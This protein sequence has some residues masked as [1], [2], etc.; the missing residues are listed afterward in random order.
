MELGHIPQILLTPALTAALARA[1]DIAV[2]SGAREVAVEH[3]LFALCDDPD[4][5]SVLETSRV[6]VAQLKVETAAYLSA[7]HPG[8]RPA[9]REAPPSSDTARILEAAAAAAR[10]GHRRDVN[11]AIV[12]AAI[13]G[14]G[15]SFAAHLLHNHGLTFDEAIRALQR[16]LAQPLSREPHAPLPHADDVL[17]RARE[18]VQSRSQP[19]LRDLIGDRGSPAAAP[20]PASPQQETADGAPSAEAPAEALPIN[21][22][23]EVG[24]GGESAEMAIEAASAQRHDDPAP[25]V[26]GEAAER[27]QDTPQE[28]PFGDEALQRQ[29]EPS[30]PAKEEAIEKALGVTRAAPTSDAAVLPQQHETGR[31]DQGM[32]APREAPFDPHFDLSPELRSGH[33]S[34]RPVETPS[35]G[36]IAIEIPRPFPVQPPPIPPPPAGWTGRPQR[37]EA[38][39]FP[40]PYRAAPAP[41]PSP[42][43]TP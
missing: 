42:R 39:A 43:P 10:G 31:P 11:G 16:S 3:L 13:V 21:D 29:P 6:D 18:R 9:A 19:T 5:V 34:A 17:A 12:L 37:P 4:A 27:I 38:D 36:P 22:E 2:A 32:F 41:T 28:P 14:D 1:S 33:W 26:E 30:P 24:D 23:P 40:F 35:Q 7:P 8:Q 25:A 20:A 15:R